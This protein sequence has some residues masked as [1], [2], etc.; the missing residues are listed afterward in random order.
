M[1]SLIITEK[2]RDFLKLCVAE[3]QKIRAETAIRNRHFRRK[4]ARDALSRELKKP[5]SRFTLSLNSFSNNSSKNRR[6]NSS[7]VSK[8]RKEPSALHTALAKIHDKNLY[9]KFVDNPYL[10]NRAAQ[11]KKNPPLKFRMIM[12]ELEE[13]EDKENY[14]KLKKNRRGQ[15][16]DIYS[17]KG[18]LDS[19]QPLNSQ[20]SKIGDKDFTK[21]ITQTSNFSNSYK[22]HKSPYS[23]KKESTRRLTAYTT[24]EKFRMSTSKKRKTDH[25]W[26]YSK[27]NKFENTHKTKKIKK[28]KFFAS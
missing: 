21:E 10:K 23:K 20:K 6:S 25:S 14:K 27:R 24:R 28:K 12:K 8:R 26:N 11:L 2:G 16:S 5:K 7:Y 22:I 17:L 3:E 18:S 15:K 1:T 13:M 9:R 19:I 4:I